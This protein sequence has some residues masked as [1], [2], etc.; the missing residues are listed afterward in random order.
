MPKVPSQTDTHF[1]SE[2]E[3]HCNFDA[4][5][6][7]AVGNIHCA[8]ESEKRRPDMAS[9]VTGTSSAE[10]SQNIYDT[11]DFFDQYIKLDRQK[12]G[13][14]GAPEWPR[15]RAML[16]DSL[17][18]LRMLDLG[19]G[20]GWY[21]RYFAENGAAHVR[22]IDISENMLDKARAL[23]KTD[24]IEYMKADLEE[25]KLPEGEYDVVFSALAFHYLVNLPELI[26]EVSRA[27][28]PKG[29]LVFSIEHPIYLGPTKG[30]FVT[31]EDGRKIW[32]L[33]AYQREGLRIRNWFVDGVRK[34]HRTLGTYINLLLDSGFE[35]TDF[36]EWCPTEEDVKRSPGWETE[37]IR[38]TFLLVGAV[39]K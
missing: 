2:V 5:V 3:Q 30:G 28:K 23:N 27:L 4:L 32:P 29:R 19:C 18:S 8:S 14:E 36:V 16:P 9:K 1:F 6:A 22:G 26:Q 10:G 13:L 35:L 25:L 33:D 12:L 31:I 15:L 24:A 34:Q 38:P 11:A 7:S 37:F 17:D 39:K 20:M 21:A